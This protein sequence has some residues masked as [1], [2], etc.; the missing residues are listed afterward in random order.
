VI[1]GSEFYHHLLRLLRL[2]KDEDLRQFVAA[3]KQQP[4]QARV[5]QG[6]CWFPVRIVN[7]GF[8][9]GD[10]A[11]V[12]LERPASV[13]T[14]HKMRAGQSVNLF[15]TNAAENDPD[16]SG[17]IHFIDRNRMK[18]ILNSQDFPEWLADP[19]LGVDMLF[20]DRSYL[21]MERALAQIM[22]AKGNRL[23]EFGRL[24][25]PPIQP[26]PTDDYLHRLQMPAGPADFAR[27]VADP[28]LEGLNASQYAAVMAI[29]D[30]RT[31]H[32]VHGPPGTGKTTTLVAAI[33]LLAKREN[34]VLV[35]APSNTAADL[36]TERLAA[37]GVQVVRIG[38]ISRVDEGVLS[39]TIDGIMA[40][41]P[42]SKHIRKVRLQAAEYR[43]QAGRHKRTFTQEDRRE[44]Q[45]LKRQSKELEQWANTLEDR[46][47]DEILSA[48]HAITCTLVGAA[49]PLLA[50]RTFRTCVIDEA[51]Q[52]LEP[53]CWIPIA[54]CSRVVLA[55]D[56]FQLPPTIK[57]LEAARLGL[58]VT[59]MERVIPLLPGQ[60]SL[61]QVQ[62]RMNRS[63][64][65]FSNQHFYGGA[66]IAHDAVKD[67]R[68]S[69]L[70]PDGELLT[71]F[72]PVAFIDTAGTG[73][74]E[75]LVKAHPNDRKGGVSRCNPDEAG[76]IRE[77]LL[78]LAGAIPGDQMPSIA[79]LSPYREQVNQLE[80]LLREDHVTAGWMESNG[81]HALLTVQTIDGFQGQERDVVYISLVRSNNKGEIGFLKDYRRM[82]V[83]M[84]RARKL[85]VVVGDSVTVGQDSFYRA[86]MAYCEQEG[87]YESA[88]SYMR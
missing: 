41:H 65:S 62:Y 18:I 46:L 26:L 50:R 2:E 58:S 88:W 22:E 59:L 20:D 78:L 14:P 37:A 33:R 64:M 10:R 1:S 72:D 44:R 57:S 60:V 66:L 34:T 40:V 7:T 28:A 15:T 70:S 81:S 87:R 67:R 36:L 32:V 82:N 63:I 17:I 83:A 85:L 71:V 49:H 73:F 80:T 30:N 5:E 79:V 51:G 38:H 9:L 86:F 19:N 39:H 52:A 56:P 76:L 11:F 12:V 6:Y 75:Q 21:E 69:G 43:R 54:K 24:L 55:G 25:A 42:E 4:L 77:H 35:T 53:A 48:A 29:L 27:T 68:L 45:H 16:A 13:Q 74:E 84:T 8:A 61:L 3:V 23:A 31:V 47:V